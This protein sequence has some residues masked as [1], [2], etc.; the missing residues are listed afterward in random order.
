M[1]QYYTDNRSR[2]PRRNPSIIEL[3][4]TILVLAAAV[5]FLVAAFFTVDCSKPPEIFNFG[6]VWVD[7]TFFDSDCKATPEG[8]GV[9]EAAEENTGDPENGTDEAEMPPQADYD[10]IMDMASNSSESGYAFKKIPI[11]PGLKV[12]FSNPGWAK[13]NL[14]NAH[15]RLSTASELLDGMM[16]LIEQ[17]VKVV[18]GSSEGEAVAITVAPIA[19]QRYCQWQAGFE[20]ALAEAVET[21]VFVVPN[22]SKVSQIQASCEAPEVTLPKIPGGGDVPPPQ[23]VP[24]AGPS[25]TPNIVSP[26]PSLVPTATQGVYASV[27]PSVTPQP[28]AKQIY[29]NPHGAVGWLATNNPQGKRVL[30]NIFDACNFADDSIKNIAAVPFFIEGEADYALTVDMSQYQSVFNGSCQALA[31]KTGTSNS[32]LTINGSHFVGFTIPA[33]PV[34]TATIG[35]PPATPT[36]APTKWMSWSHLDPT[37]IV[38]ASWFGDFTVAPDY[39]CSNG[40]VVNYN[41]VH[42]INQGQGYLVNLSQYANYFQGNCAGIRLTTDALHVDGYYMR[43]GVADYA[44]TEWV[45]VGFYNPLGN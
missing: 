37:N 4:L 7:E 43:F 1:S 25:P 17:Q 13:E 39:A 11:W 30:V 40:S 33:K 14:G 23:G 12:A 24:T 45:I 20:Q 5:Y 28:I 15:V 6:Y 42:M 22:E 36:P 10:V 27:L 34:P 2:R 19:G 21:G 35:A 18:P 44:Q 29:T 32:W 41:Q 9:Y 38:L 31:I 16:W 3:V 8:A 26:T